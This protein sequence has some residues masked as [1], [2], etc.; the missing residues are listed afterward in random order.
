MDAVSFAVLRRALDCLALAEDT[1]RS[2]DAML[3]GLL[4]VLSEAPGL[5]HAAVVLLDS[6]DRPAIRASLGTPDMSLILSATL[7]RGPQALLARVLRRGEAAVVADLDGEVAV[8][9]SEA[10]MLAA[11]VV[12]G[13]TGCG[14]FF[15][16]GLL[17][18]QASL[19]AELR[20]AMFVA[21]LIG[22]MADMANTAIVQGSGLIQ[23]LTF[24]RSKVSLRYRHIFSDGQSAVMRRLR[25]EADRAAL[26]DAPV[27]LV[28]EDGTGRAVLARL[29]HE[30]SPRAV[31]PFAI[32]EAG[33][34]TEA[35][36][37]GLRLFGSARGFTGGS[38]PGLLEEA[39][40]GMVLIEDAHLLHPETAK[41]LAG[42]LSTGTFSRLGG[43]R[44]RRATTRLA[45]QIPAGGLSPELAAAT[46]PQIIR[47]PSLRERREDIPAL[48]DHL[49]ALEAA[50]SG[51]RMTLTSKALRALE[52]YD[53][54]GNIREMELMTTRLAMTAPEDRIDIADIPPEVL[55]E[56]ERPPVLPEDAAELRDMER[57]QV[58][59]ALE[60]HGWVQSRAARELG[61][62]LRQIGY[63]IRKYGLAR[64]D[65]DAP[66]A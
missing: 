60:R 8:A 5:G 40:G 25:S 59:S 41:R 30:L 56:G 27:L 44:L 50:R 12:I 33:D 20:T 45:F 42:Y 57:Q 29:I 32:F 21:G 46:P 35:A 31:R 17:G 13:E 6:D 1:G 10:A 38:S 37:A 51:R 61:L 4:A 15:A 48:L 16:D 53:W 19:A 24:L 26:S 18:G 34:E 54:P 39:E 22:R 3:A 9:R 49:L 63:R 7:E 43:G 55:T 2:L 28:G 14:W 47:L 66:A 65:D 36:T 23:E 11:P 58:L 62:T 64:D 52:T